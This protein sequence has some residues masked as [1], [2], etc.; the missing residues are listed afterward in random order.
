MGLDPSVPQPRRGSIHD[1]GDEGVDP[2]GA[3]PWGSIRDIEP[4][5]RA[6][7][8]RPATAKGLDPRH[9]RR[10]G[11][12]VRSAAAGVDPRYRAPKKG[13]I[14]A[15]RDRKGARSATPATRGSIRPGRSR[16]G[17][18]AIS[19]P[20]RGSTHDTGDEG[21]DSSGGAAVGGDPRYRA[22]EGA[23]SERPATPKGLDPRHRGR[24]GR[25]VRG[26]AVGVDPRYRAPKKGSI[27]ASRNPEGA[28]STTPATRGS[29][30]PERRRGGRSAISSPQEGFDP[31]VPRPRRGSIRDTG[32]EGVDPSGAPPR[33]SIRD[34]EPPKGLDP[35]VPRPR[36][37][38][39]HDTGGEGVDPS[40]APP[41]GSIRD[42]EPPNGARSGRP[43][44]AK[45]LDPRHRR[46]G[47]RSVR[48]AAVGV[49]PRYRAPKKGSIRAS[50]NPEEAR[51]ATSATRGS[52]RPE[53]RRGGRSAISSPKKGS[54]RASRD[55]EGARCR[56][57]AKSGQKWD[58]KSG[59]SSGS[60]CGV[61]GR[62]EARFGARRRSWL[63]AT[64]ALLREGRAE[65]GLGTAPER[66]PAPCES[67]S[68][69][70]ATAEGQT[71]PPADRTPE[72]PPR[73]PAPS[74]EASPPFPRPSGRLPL[75]READPVTGGTDRARQRPIAGRRP[76]CLRPD[77]AYTPLMIV[78]RGARR[79]VGGRKPVPVHCKPRIGAGLRG[80]PGDRPPP[81]C[82]R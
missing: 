6:R 49:D 14:R 68:W 15:S 9:R 79:V 39:I 17:R 55:R 37:G 50:R 71:P 35:S 77:S 36:R 80:T 78:R 22:P 2:S 8:E 1:T 51:S 30:R 69:R 44:T 67:G 19:S 45:G 57:D 63:P 40:G 29:I 66:R 33:G 64:P 10:G 81:F 20:Q 16:G 56:W 12:S 32:G 47:G 48:S 24:G 52:I 27:R 38:S 61:E 21:V 43:A 5:K 59:H 53:R 23:R 7:S 4:P 13:S 18:S 76:R 25:F 75:T 42:I 73:P 41:W 31:G 82:R 34:I 74:A 54:I 46:R 65:A 26:A 58:P 11:R 60:G 28:R 62:V 70:L 3:T 72:G